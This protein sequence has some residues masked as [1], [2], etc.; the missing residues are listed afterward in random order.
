M[1]HVDLGDADNSRVINLTSER[2]VGTYG[3]KDMIVVVGKDKT[4]VAKRTGN[5]LVEALLDIL[6]DYSRT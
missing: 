5:K 2:L 6:E 1:P 3:L 4:V